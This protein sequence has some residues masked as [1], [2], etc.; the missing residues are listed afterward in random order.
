[1]LEGRCLNCL[2]IADGS[3][4]GAPTLPRRATPADL[5]RFNRTQSNLAYS[6]RNVLN[7][8][9]ASPMASGRR[10]MARASSTMP[11]VETVR[12]GSSRSRSPAPQHANFRRTTST[13]PAFGPREASLSPPRLPSRKAIPTL[14]DTDGIEGDFDGSGRSGA[15]VVAE[16]LSS[17]GHASF[18]AELPEIGSPQRRRHSRGSIPPIRRSSSHSD[19]DGSA[20]KTP[21]RSTLSKRSNTGDFPTPE[22]LRRAQLTILAAKQHGIYEQASEENQQLATSSDTLEDHDTELDFQAALRASEQEMPVH[23]SIMQEE[24]DFQKALQA[25]TRHLLMTPHGHDNSQGYNNEIDGYASPLNR[26]GIFQLSPALSSPSTDVPAPISGSSDIRSQ[27]AEPP[28]N[29]LE[30]DEN[31][32]ESKP[33]FGDSAHESS[34]AEQHYLGELGRAG[35]NYGEILLTLREAFDSAPVV[36][37][38]LKQLS[39][40][41]LSPEEQNMLGEMGAPLVISDIMHSHRSSMPVQL[42]ACGAIW[43]MSSTTQNQVTFVDCGILDGL[44]AAMD[45]FDNNAELQEKAIAA[46]SNLSAAQSNLS[47]LDSKGAVSRIVNAMNKYS[48]VSSLQVKCFGAVTNLASHDVDM[49]ERM[50]EAGTGG[51]IVVA[52]VMHANDPYVQEKAL[53]ALRSLCANSEP[54]KVELANIGGIDSV[55]SAMQ[56]HRDEEGV[57]LEGAWTL[58]A[59]AGNADNKGVIGDCGGV[60]VVVRAMWVHSDKIPVQEWCCRA[61][62][63]LTLDQDNCDVVLEIGGISAIINAMQAHVDCQTVQEMGCAILGNLAANDQTRMRIVDEEAL[64]AIVLAMVLHIDDMQVQ[65]RACV[66]LMRLTIPSNYNAM[67]AANI[68]ELVRTAARKFPDQC[69]ESARQILSAF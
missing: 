62:F 69:D 57:Q 54:N 1:V 67:K 44:L 59:L 42:A 17:A 21:S 40:L 64:D 14:N 3:T 50:V 9:G 5:E 15:A 12:T 65:E 37:A 35:Q 22:E 58:S 4:K 23:N 33:S 43:S 53:R 55:I 66:A 10:H 32:V 31:R 19:A 38:G 11:R 52:M 63:T 39:S 24:L 20:P 18:V 61:L 45:L 29:A 34:P 7:G 56:V 13:S 48:E 16:S 27:V 68:P 46:L 6:S 25:S 47:S 26:G 60:D 51:A 36:S 49:K 41:A 28:M 2:P 8:S 30:R